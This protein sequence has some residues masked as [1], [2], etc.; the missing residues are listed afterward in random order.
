MNL[1]FLFCP[2]GNIMGRRKGPWTPSETAAAD[3][4]VRLGPVD[5]A[6]TALADFLEQ[7]VGTDAVP[8]PFGRLAT[9]VISPWHHFSIG[10]I[11]E[12]GCQC[13]ELFLLNTVSD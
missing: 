11:S 13:S 10:I 7:L 5:D 9:D 8:G 12:I 3:G 4:F 1:T 6:A 2:G